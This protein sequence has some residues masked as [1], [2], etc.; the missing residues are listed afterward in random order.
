MPK[1]K[2]YTISTVIFKSLEDVKKQ[3]LKWEKADGFREDSMIF[4][5]KEVLGVKIEPVVK[6]KK[7]QLSE[8]ET[9]KLK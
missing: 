4:E 9:K 2:Y 6:A 1:V 5:V 8:L 3:I 7:L